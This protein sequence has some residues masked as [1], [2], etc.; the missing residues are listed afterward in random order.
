M[1][2]P[3]G[4]PKA[5]ERF[6]HKATGA[7]AEVVSRTGNGLDY[8]LVMKLIQSSDGTGEVFKPSRHAYGYPENHFWLLEASYWLKRDWLFAEKVERANMID[9]YATK[10]HQFFRGEQ[11]GTSHMPALK[12]MLEQFRDEIEAK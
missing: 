11:D 9:Y 4:L 12:S 10:I 7:V 2:T 6:I 8:G 5:G 3:G 1:P